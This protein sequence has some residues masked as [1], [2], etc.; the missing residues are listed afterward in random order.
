MPLSDTAIRKAKPADKTQRL[1]DGGGLYLEITPAGGKLWRQKYRFGGKEKRLAH[2]TYPEVSLAEARDRRDNARKLLAA[3]TD[4]GEHRKAEKQA[5]EDRAANSF[6]AVAREWFGKFAPNWAASHAGKIMGRLEND[7]FPWIGSRPVAE[8]KAPELLRCLR[9]IESRG[10]LETAHRVLQNA[11]QVFRYAIATGRAD[12]DPSTD[13]RGALA[14][15]KPQHYPAPT[16]PKAVGELLRAIDGYTGGNVVKAMLRL[17]PLVFV[18]PGELRQAEWAEIDLEAAEWNIPAHKM[19][20][21]EPHMV[22]LSRQAIEILTDLQPLTGNRAHVFPGG[23]D[24]RKPM[25]EAALNAALRRMGYD[26]TTMTAHGFR[27]IARTL[28]DEELGFRPD[29]IEHQ[30]AHAV[31]DPNGRAYNRTAHLAARRKMMQA[32]ADYLDRRRTDTGK[33]LEFKKSGSRR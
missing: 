13:L 9:R 12:R 24:P 7:L 14:P 25:S 1:F 5:G 6:E 27:A 30:L 2:G 33:I 17:A 29:Y 8:I 31:R 3:G 15:W 21:R 10:A 22:P 4:P 20:M 16:D 18:R 19:K 26:K 32:W 23:H 28:L 11:G